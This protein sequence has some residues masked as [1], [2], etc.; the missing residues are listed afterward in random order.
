MLIGV[1]GGFTTIWNYTTLKRVCNNWLA[2]LG[3]TTIWNYTTLKPYGTGAF[4]AYRFTTIWNYT[5]L[6]L[7][8]RIPHHVKCFTTI[9]NYTTLKLN[10]G[11]KAPAEVLLPYGITLLSN[12]NLRV[13]DTTTFALP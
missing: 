3:F 10:L 4:V 6:K 12:L 2:Y 13:N 7:S 1:L 9:W 5:T 11:D 8:S